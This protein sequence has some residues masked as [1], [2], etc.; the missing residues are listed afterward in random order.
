[1]PCSCFA[2]VRTCARSSCVCQSSQSSVL[3][4]TDA[5]QIFLL[6]AETLEL[7]GLENLID[8]LESLP[9]LESVRIHT[10]PE[11]DRKLESRRFKADERFL[12]FALTSSRQDMLLREINARLQK[13]KDGKV[14]MAVGLNYIDG[15]TA[16]QERRSGH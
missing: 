16:W 13:V 9:R 6:H 15:Y 3:K 4:T 1:M 12:E 8:V 5:L 14:K 2:S 7:S 10:E 11:R